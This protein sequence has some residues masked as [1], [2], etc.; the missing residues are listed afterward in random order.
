MTSFSLELLQAVSDWQKGAKAVRYIGP[1][2][3]QS[4]DFDIVA[5]GIGRWDPIS[6]RQGGKLDAAA[7]EEGV[8][9][10]EQRFRTLARNCCEGCI[11]LTAGAGVDDVDLQLQR[12]RRFLHLSQRGL[13]SR[14]IAG[15]DQHG[16]ANDP[17]NQIT[18]QPQSLQHHLADEKIDARRVAAG[19]REVGD[20]TKLDRI[21][22]NPLPGK[23]SFGV[24]HGGRLQSCVRPVGAVRVDCWP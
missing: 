23:R 2:A 17:G 16:D 13:G 9:R 6:R 15:V 10:Y 12:V 4:A 20:K 19:P 24:Q 21:L 8:G 3:H 14:N 5:S 1:V 18:Q 22:A 7:V 11:D